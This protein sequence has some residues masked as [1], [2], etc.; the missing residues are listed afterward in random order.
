[1]RVR[2]GWS[3]MV[4][5]TE[6]DLS[7]LITACATSKMR[8]GSPS[9]QSGLNSISEKLY[10]ARA[11]LDTHSTAAPNPRTN[12]G[13][14]TTM[15]KRFEYKKMTGQEFRDDLKAID[16]T[17]KA[18]ARITGSNADRVIKWF[19]GEEDIPAWVPVLTS[20]LKNIPGAL[21]EARQVAAER[22]M[23]DYA[24][25]TGEEFPYLKKEADDDD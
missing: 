16:M 1:V 6:A 9:W 2:M 15:R 7:N 11:V 17:V 10:A 22:I 20:I 23:R 3:A 14:G 21:P 8:D 24:D 5:L 4:D 19:H 25:P 18:F 12:A 13:K